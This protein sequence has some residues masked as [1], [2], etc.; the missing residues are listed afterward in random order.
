MA[1]SVDLDQTKHPAA[2]DPSPNCLYRPSITGEKAK[3]ERDRPEA[4]DLGLNG[5]LRMSVRFLG[6]YLVTMP[7][8][9]N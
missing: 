2:A 3:P 1:N 4:S 8:T 7:T 6:V 5:L 9:I